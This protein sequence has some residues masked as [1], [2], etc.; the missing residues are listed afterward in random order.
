MPPL[1]GN[2]WGA[3]GRR[4]HFN[5]TAAVI[6]RVSGQA[7][8]RRDPHRTNQ[9]AAA[10]EFVAGLI[11][12]VEAIRKTGATTLDAMTRALN[13]RAIDRPAADDGM[14][15][16]CQTYS[17]VRRTCQRCQALH[18]RDIDLARSPRG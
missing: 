2:G 17:P 14:S 15:P 3:R 13:D 1:P 6:A 8:D 4:R 5:S 11:P 9:T 10:D 7:P 16:R 12:V 18:R